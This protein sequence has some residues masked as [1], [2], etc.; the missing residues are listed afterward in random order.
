[1]TQSISGRDL[2]HLVIEEIWNRGVLEI[3]GAL[4]T[5]DYMNHGGLIADLVP[6]TRGSQTQRGALPQCLSNIPHRS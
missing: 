4:F 2:V 6:R 3:A 5:H 1:M